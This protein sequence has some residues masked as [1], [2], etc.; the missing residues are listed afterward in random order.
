MRQLVQ[1]SV[2]LVR[3]EAAEKT[4]EVKELKGSPWKGYYFSISDR[5]P[6][7]EGFKYMTQGAMLI[8]NLLTTF[9][10]LTNEGQ[11][12]IHSETLRMLKGAVRNIPT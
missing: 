9:T 12:D 10:I 3:S 2:E 1:Q 7:P 4:I 11:L 8:G 6:K 5:A